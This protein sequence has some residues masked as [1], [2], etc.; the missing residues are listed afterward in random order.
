ME[1]TTTPQADLKTLVQAISDVNQPLFEALQEQGLQP[2]LGLRR[3]ARLPVLSA[4]YT[5]FQGP[6]L[7]ITDRADHALTSMEEISLWQPDAPRLLYPEPTP[8]FY[9]KAA[10]GESTRRERL[11]ALTALAAY[12]IPGAPV[13]PKPPILIAPARA[14]MTRTLPAPRLP[15]SRPDVEAG[16]IAA[17]GGAGA[18][19]CVALGYENVNTVIAPGQFARRG[20]ILDIWPP[21]ESQPVRL[22]FFGDEIDTLRTLR[23][24]QPTHGEAERA[25]KDHAHAGAR[26]RAQAQRRTQQWEEQEISEFLIPYLHPTPA[27]LLDYLPRQALVLIDDR[28]AAGK[29]HL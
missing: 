26:I 21:A 27:S 12:H 24:C 14:L 29:R 18:R 5:A 22:E 16:P 4:L 25:R 28:Q 1:L 2:S 17:S 13:S 3:S 9:E 8:L 19:S 10:W 20:G 23:P 15:Q 6:I 7:Y 11:T